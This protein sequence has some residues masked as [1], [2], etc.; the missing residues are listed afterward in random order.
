MNFRCLYC[1]KFLSES[2]I[3][4]VYKFIYLSCRNCKYP[5]YIHLIDNKV[6]RYNFVKDNMWI[7]SNFIDNKTSVYLPANYDSLD[8]EFVLL[9]EVFF[10]IKNQE[11][12]NKIIPRIKK[13]LPF[14]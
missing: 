9:L 11:D 10:N 13:L 5:T 2:L 8:W 1:D 12:L 6:I 14:I 7:L 4:S 3:E